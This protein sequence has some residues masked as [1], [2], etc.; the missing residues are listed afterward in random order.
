M[1][2]K[3]SP[4]AGRQPGKNPQIVI[5]DGGGSVIFEIH[6]E[7]KILGGFDYIHQGHLSARECQALIKEL[8]YR[9]LI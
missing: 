2:Y 8:H 3:E 9:Q 4:A 7:N 1:I 5:Y 6:F